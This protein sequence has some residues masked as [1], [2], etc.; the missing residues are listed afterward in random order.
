MVIGTKGMGQYNRMCSFLEDNGIVLA[1]TTVLDAFAGDGSF[2]SLEYM[3]RVKHVTAWDT[4][5]EKLLDLG[6]NVG[7]SE[8][9]EPQCVDSIH[10]MEEHQLEQDRKWD[11]IILDNPCALYGGEEYC[12]HFEILQNAFFCRNTKKTNALVFNVTPT[13][14]KWNNRRE[15]HI[16]RTVYYDDV[17][18]ELPEISMR[19]HYRFY[20]GNWGG[21]IKECLYIKHKHSGLEAG[22]YWVAVYVFEASRT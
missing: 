18:A 6:R 17:R 14:H 15:H 13:P 22:Y 11:V 19:G 2:R 16:R 1:D 5:W 3:D 8:R 21:T 10:Q 20:F 4:N 9:I 7:D 12:E